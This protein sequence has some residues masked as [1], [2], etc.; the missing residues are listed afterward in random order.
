MFGGWIEWVGYAASIAI[1]ISLVMTNMVK[2]R[3]INSIGCVLFVIYG[4]LVGAYPVVISNAAIIV[5]NA[6]QLHKLSKE[7]N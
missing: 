1:V 4:I 6:Y 7:T 2:L 5:I 3:M